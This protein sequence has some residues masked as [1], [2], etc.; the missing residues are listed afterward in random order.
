M[1]AGN[2]LYAGDSLGSFHTWDEFQTDSVKEIPVVSTTLEN[3][4]EL[5]DSDSDADNLNQVP[6]ETRRIIS[7]NKHEAEPSK[8]HQ[9]SKPKKSK[10]PDDYSST[11]DYNEEEEEIEYRKNQ[12]PYIMDE[13]SE[14]S[15]GDYEYEEEGRRRSRSNQSIPEFKKK[16]TS[17]DLAQRIK[18]KFNIQEYSTTPSETETESD[19]D[20]PLTKEEIKELREM[21]RREKQLDNDFIVGSGSEVSEHEEEEEAIEAVL[22]SG[23]EISDFEEHHDLHQFMPSS[24]DY[25][26]NK[27]MFLCCNLIAKIYLRENADETTCI[28]VDYNDLSKY[29]SIHF[30]NKEKLILGTVSSTGVALASRSR[31]HYKTHDF[32]NTLTSEAW[33]NDKECIIRMDYDETIDLIAAGNGWFAISTSIRRLRIFMAS[34]LE[35]GLLNIPQRPMTMI[36][37]DDLLAVIYCNIQNIEQDLFYSLYDVKKRSLISEGPM[38]IKKEIKWIG[39]EDRTLY[40]YGN[41]H[42]LYALIFDFGYQFVPIAN[43]QSKHGDFTEFWGVGVSDGQFW[44]YFLPNDRKFPEPSNNLKLKGID[45]E[46][47]CVDEN[48]IDYLLKRY[49]YCNS[50]KDDKEKMAIKMDIELLKQFGA[51]EKNKLYEKMYQIGL[52]INSKKGQKA[53]L[54]FARKKDDKSQE[55]ADKL[56]EYYSSF[57]QNDDSEEE[58]KNEQQNEQNENEQNENEQKSESDEPEKSQSDDDANRS[59]ILEEAQQN[60]SDGREDNKDENE[61]GEELEND[62][63]ENKSAESNQ[64]NNENDEDEDDSENNDEDEDDNEDDEDSIAED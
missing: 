7:R 2:Q 30:E 25:F 46:P 3:E 40:V 44:G 51:A 6:K 12:N 60:E 36:G 32:K 47:Q 31:V 18:D 61:A 15:G 50:S 35:I 20:R 38:P 58:T 63:N 56:E 62:E 64:E 57:N 27:R 55:I 29:R 43:V 1:W 21:D 26:E 48:S 14:S 59:R 9:K 17:E 5:S 16:L 19:H 37:G 8:L 41:D 10:L 4:N 45:I 34:G 24:T 52:Q 42:V 54:D 13:A 23:S 22:D 39:F 11:A 53:V 33:A 49:V 28:D